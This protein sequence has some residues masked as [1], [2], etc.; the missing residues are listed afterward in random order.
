[1]SLPAGLVAAHPVGGPRGPNGGGRGGRGGGGGLPMLLLPS[2]QSP[3]LLLLVS[4]AAGAA[5][6][7]NC[8]VDLEGIKRPDDDVPVS[9][10]FFFKLRFRTRSFAAL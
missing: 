2:L 3:L 10:V 6:A 9:S 1:M 5:S 8:Y 7:L 4:L